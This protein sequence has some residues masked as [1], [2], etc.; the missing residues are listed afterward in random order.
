L[1]DSSVLGLV[2]LD[3]SSFGI[4]GSLNI[5]VFVHILLEGSNVRSLNSE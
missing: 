4:C 1:M 2:T 3:V 5:K